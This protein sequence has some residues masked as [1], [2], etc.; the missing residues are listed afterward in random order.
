MKVV[1]AIVPMSL[2]FLTIWLGTWKSPDVNHSGD[3]NI[4][5]CIHSDD[6]QLHFKL[7]VGGGHNFDVY[8]VENSKPNYLNP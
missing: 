5:T 4:H 6:R 3:T 8:L 7:D 2:C 1:Q